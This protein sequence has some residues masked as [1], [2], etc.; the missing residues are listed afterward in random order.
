M[1]LLAWH[2]RRHVRFGGF[3]VVTSCHRKKKGPSP[4]WSTRDAA[5]SQ[6]RSKMRCKEVS[7]HLL[8]LGQRRI[9]AWFS[10]ERG[11]GKVGQRPSFPS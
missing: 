5:F 3:E 6:P 7:Y 1:D 9:F 8:S 11:V 2:W 4:L 10:L